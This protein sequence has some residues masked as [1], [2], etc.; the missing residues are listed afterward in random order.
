[1]SEL[2]TVCPTC[3]RASAVSRIREFSTIDTLRDFDGRVDDYHESWV[4]YHCAHCDRHYAVQ[5]NEE[6]I[7]THNDE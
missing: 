7:R 5:V 3:E 1:M 6:H 2:T 4:R